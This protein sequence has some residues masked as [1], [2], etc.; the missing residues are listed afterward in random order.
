MLLL[1]AFGVMNLLAVAAL[2]T[3]VAVEKRWR[4]GRSFA[5]VVGVVSLAWAVAALAEPGLVPGLHPMM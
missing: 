2:A 3:V 1:F 5:R 4:H